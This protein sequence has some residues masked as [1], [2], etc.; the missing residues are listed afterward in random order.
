MFRWA[1]KKS[2]T[3]R[4][5]K[6]SRQQKLFLFLLFFPILYLAGSGPALWSR[7][8]TSNRQWRKAVVY[9][10]VP[11]MW[12]NDQFRERSLIERVGSV[13]LTRSNDRLWYRYLESY[14]GFF[15][16]DTLTEGRKIALMLKIKFHGS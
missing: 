5:R 8:Q 13:D 7:T 6:T 12:A 3:G 14:W 9:Y 2:K 15:G 10:V 16:Q 11:V 1:S 4:R